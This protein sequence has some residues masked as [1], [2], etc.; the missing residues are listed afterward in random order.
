MEAH[1]YLFRESAGGS[2]NCRN[3]SGSSNRSLH[4]YAIAVDLN[5]SVNP[6]GSPLRHDYPAAF[7]T[8][9][10]AIRFGGKQAFTWGGRWNTPDAMHWQLDLPPSAYGGQ[11]GGDDVKDVV[12]GIQRSLAAAGYDPGTIDGVWGPRTE[13]AHAEMTADAA[14]TGGGGDLAR[15]DT[16]KLV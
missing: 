6:F 15:G 5:P 11:S 9:V 2:Y 1:G 8:D 3:I 16:V 4:A 14:R 7:I 10:E 12:K 13:R